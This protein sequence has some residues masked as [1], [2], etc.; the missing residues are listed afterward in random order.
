MSKT[1][2]IVVLPGD[3][4]GPEVTKE[5]VNILQTVCE[6]HGYKLKTRTFPI[7]GASIDRY[8]RPLTDE[9][10]KA[11]KES[12][13]IL[14]GAVGGVKWNDQPKDKRPEAALLGLRKELDL[15]ANLRPIKTYDS[16]IHAS[17]LKEEIITDVD[18]M[19]VRELT[20]GIYFGRPRYIEKTETGER[21]VDTK[22][23]TTEEIDRIA[24][25]AFETATLRDRRVTS[26][27]KANVLDS[28]R[29]WRQTV[30]ESAK[31]WPEV[32]LD[33]MLVDNGAMQ[34]VRNPGQFDV[35][36]TGNMF[37]DILSDEASMITGSLGM[38]PS[39]SLGEEYA[40]YEPIHGSAPDIA[41]QHIA[42]P[43]ATIA[44]VAMMCRHSLDMPDAAREI[45]LAIKTTLED[46]FRT[47][48]IY[49]DP[50]N[51]YEV[52]TSEMGS[53]VVKHLNPNLQPGT[54]L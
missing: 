29:L 48:D 5:A 30:K 2:E 33:H 17:P 37:G 44:S 4:I 40:M 53:A 23:Y 39:A 51:E 26:V 34:L 3:G 45:E 24:H 14:L 8:G 31:Q 28:S 27:D 32:S 6:R 54:F 49:S 7:G 38:L 18:I 22:A 52:S 9:T 50:A 46:G 41:G 21:A 43:L 20:G 16:L 25:I 35:I 36:V 10:L 11:C 13:A 42:N 15:F 12:P 19:I 1:K 47:A